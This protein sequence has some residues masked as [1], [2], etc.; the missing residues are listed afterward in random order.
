[1]KFIL[2][3]FVSCLFLSFIGLAHASEIVKWS[4]PKAQKAGEEF[5]LYRISYSGIFTAFIWKDLADTVIF[6]ENN[7][8]KFDHQKSC[9]LNL[10]MSTEDFSISE[11]F[12]PMRF[13]W[14]TVVS[15]DLNSV[16]LIE[17]I[18]ENSDDRHDV[19][20]LNQAKKRIEFFHKR[21]RLPVQDDAGVGFYDDE[22]EFEDKP[23]VL[24]WEQD[25]RKTPPEFLVDKPDV[26]DDITYLVHDKSVNVTGNKPV[27][28]P[29]SLIY[30]ARWYDYSRLKKIDFVVSYKD[31]FRN[32]QVRYEGKTTLNVGDRQ[33]ESLRIEIRRN[34]DEARENEAFMVMWLSDDE[35]RI[36]LQYLVEMDH[37]AMKLEINTSNLANYQA[38]ANCINTEHVSGPKPSTTTIVDS[39]TSRP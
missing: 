16:L 33:F 15:P 10:K 1:M 25:G 34:E 17:K 2:N 11:V 23:D 12:S 9:R 39:K 22:D 30:S 21:K 14:R 20:W 38:P 24:V 28:D 5:L 27:F 32:Y 31:T 8:Y 6:A 36:P 18:N 26:E 29:L 13:H 7:S 3:L 19:V 35:R 4:L 37:G